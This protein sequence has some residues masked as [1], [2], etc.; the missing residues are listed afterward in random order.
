M[1]DLA[2]NN[3]IRFKNITKKKSGLFANF[4]AKGIRGGTAFTASIAVDIASVD[5]DLSD[6]SIET[7][8]EECAKVAERESKRTELQFEG[9]A[10]V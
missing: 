10:S 2:E 4:K 5:V 3:V 9:M 7:V 6:D 8:I 1:T